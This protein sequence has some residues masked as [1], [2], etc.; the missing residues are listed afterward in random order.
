MNTKLS[1]E[2]IK[3]LIEYHSNVINYM[4][5]D[6]NLDYHTARLRKLAMTYKMLTMTQ[7][8]GDKVK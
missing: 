8:D 1:K 5:E 2:E 4:E 6:S 3:A 7:T